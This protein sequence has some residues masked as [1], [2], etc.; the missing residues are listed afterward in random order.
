MS[1]ENQHSAFINFR[2]YYTGNMSSKEKTAFEKH[3]EE[4]AFAKEAYEGF[5]VLEN[6]HARISA[7]ENTNMAL[8]EK[9]Q[10]NETANIFPL[11][12][13]LGIAASLVLFLGSYFIIQSN[14]FNKNESLA[15]NHI[16]EEETISAPEEKEVSIN[17]I[18]TLAQELYNDT[19]YD[20]QIAQ[21][22]SEA[23][24]IVI[25]EVEQKTKKEKTTTKEKNNVATPLS[26]KEKQITEKEFDKYRGQTQE[27]V[28][29]T[30][31]V[32]DLNKK[33]NGNISEKEKAVSPQLTNTIYA[34]D[35]E[36]LETEQKKI[37]SEYKKGIDAYN[38]SD[39]NKAIKYFNNS[40]DQNR[41]IAG[42][43]YYIG[44][45]YFNLNKSVKAIKYFDTTIN[46]NSTFKDNAKWYKSLTLLKKNNTAEA[47][48]LLNELIITN[49][50]FKN[51]A[52][53]KLE[54]LD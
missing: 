44:M 18:D 23:E 20:S 39:F 49:S 9:F 17:S 53:K 48:A 33:T 4:D 45:S 31:E 13:S 21:A 52:I 3:L 26:P 6:D 10:I 24:D 37:L 40:L 47:K 42:S 36:V 14:I 46:L 54:S 12:Y 11:K 32:A 22:E 51:A 2:K 41:S 35:S 50:S 29:S 38:N 19:L 25:S 7:I 27:E 43:N 8:K 1:T 5:L 15:D 34:D 16:E 30:N 28:S